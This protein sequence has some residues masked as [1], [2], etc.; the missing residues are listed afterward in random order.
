[1]YIDSIPIDEPDRYHDSLRE[2]AVNAMRDVIK[3]AHNMNELTALFE[4]ASPYMKNMCVIA[5]AIGDS[6]AANASKD[7]IEFP[8]KVMLD[9]DDMKT[10]KAFE[11]V[12][13]KSV[14]ADA[15]QNRV[16]NVYKAEAD[17][18]QKAQEKTQ[19]IIDKLAEINNDKLEERSINNTINAVSNESS[20]LFHSIF[21]NKSKMILNEAGAGADLEQF[22]TDILEETLCTYT[23]LECLHSHGIKTFD[24]N[25][26]EHLKTQFLIGK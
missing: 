24:N 6:K 4:N 21:M 10:I 17:N 9:S 16:V 8:Q 18:A 12:Q 23:L 7:N 13:G 3:D 15:L 11:K 5:E 14:Y 20:S 2:S 26:R 19:A 1:M 25:E 22:S